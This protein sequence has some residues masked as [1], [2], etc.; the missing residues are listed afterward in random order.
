MVEHTRSHQSTPLE[1]VLNCFSPLT[2]NSL[3]NS[4]NLTWQSISA[5]LKRVWFHFKLIWIQNGSGSLRST[6]GPIDHVK[7]NLTFTAMNH[8]SWMD[9][10]WIDKVTDNRKINPNQSSLY[11]LNINNRWLTH[12]IKQTM[13]ACTY[14]TAYT[15]MHIIKHNSHLLQSGYHAAWCVSR[16]D[17]SIYRL[18][19]G[20]IHITRVICPRLDIARGGTPRA[21]SSRGADT[22]WYEFCHAITYLSHD[23]KGLQNKK[24][25]L[26]P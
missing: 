2:F 8:N 5:N 13:N 20:K 4:Q 11:P 17:S 7:M 23:S 22:R 24:G 19:H 9:G 26:E 25:L 15:R 6:D 1:K 14:G 3:T 18:L 21:I 10:V 12:S 16:V